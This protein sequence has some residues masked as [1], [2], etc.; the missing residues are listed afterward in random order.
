M[1]L[2]SSHL[3][4]LVSYWKASPYP[5]I[6]SI[7]LLFSPQVCTGVAQHQFK[8][9]SMVMFASN[10]MLLLSMLRYVPEKF[11]SIERYLWDSSWDRRKGSTAV[12]R[13]R[14]YLAFSLHQRLI[15]LLYSG[16]QACRCDMALIGDMDFSHLSSP[17]WKAEK[18][19]QIKFQC[20]VIQIP[21]M[22][23]NES[24]ALATH[25]F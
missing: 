10:L 8:P 14:S 13:L 4:V 22:L 17:I 2:W 11:L 3:G 24:P 20:V 7:S 19:V 16:M 5:R 25:S 9:L 12:C 23:A 6:I 21:A 18:V 1:K 15:S